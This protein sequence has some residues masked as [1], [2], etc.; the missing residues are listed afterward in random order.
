MRN[1]LYGLI[2]LIIVVGTVAA[3]G[4]AQGQDQAAPNYTANV[5]AALSDNTDTAGF[6]RAETARPFQFPLDYGAHPDFQTEWWYYTGNLADSAGRRFG[7]EFTI[8]RRALSPTA[9]ARQSEWATNQIYFADLALTDVQGNKFYSTER[10]SR[11]A[12]GLAGATTDPSLK[13]GSRIGRWLPRI[14]MRP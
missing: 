3:I 6:A 2:G 14:P 7:F 12:A 11:G 4:L 9:P 1:I 10:F 13:S 8:F 5:I